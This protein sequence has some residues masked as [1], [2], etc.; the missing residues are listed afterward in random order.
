M[1]GRLRI[2]I[3]GCGSVAERYHLPALKRSFDWILAAICEPLEKRRDR[4]LLMF[5]GTP[6]Y[7]SFSEFLEKSHLDAVLIVTPPETHW[8]LAIQALDRGI[9]VLVEKPMALNTEDGRFIFEASV[10]VGKKLWVGFNRR[11]KSPYLKLREKLKL[12]PPESIKS[13]YF[14]LIF[15][16]Q[17]WKSITPYLGDDARGGG[18][19]DDVASHQI[20]LL[21]W[22]TS[23]PVKAVK[24]KQVQQEPAL[25]DCI[26]YELTFENDLVAQCMAAHGRGYSEYLAL[27]TNETKLVASAVTFLASSRMPEGMIRAYCWM[28]NHSHFVFHKYNR[29]SNVTDIS[30]EMQ[31]NAFAASIKGGKGFIEGADAKSGV[32]T[33]RVIEACRMSIMGGGVWEPAILKGEEAS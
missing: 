21:S 2:G 27:Q 22:L 23:T 12:V 9:H 18:V 25:Y 15:D 5:P 1:S 4:A 17:N 24:G 13:I 19:L 14:E 28:R 3:V 8:K 6:V 33:L 11:F 20:D 10:R 31:L 30:F 7:E 32:S 29:T 26:R 16:P